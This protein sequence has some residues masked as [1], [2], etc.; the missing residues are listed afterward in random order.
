MELPKI[1]ALGIYDSD[2]SKPNVAISKN[3]K[4][5]MFEIEL[6]I[7]DGGVSYIDSS[8]ENIKKNMLI[9][10]KPGQV[11]HT[12]FPFKCFYV[13]MIVK[14]GILYDI[15]MKT[16]DF[17]EI[18]NRDKYQ[19]LFSEMTGNY[20]N[21]SEVRD[22]MVQSKLLELIYLINE[23]ISEL[24]RQKGSETNPDLI[25]KTVKYIDEHLTEDLSLEKLASINS[26]SSIHF[27]NVFKSATGKTLRTYVEEQRLKKAMQLLLTTDFTLTRIAYECGFSSQSYFSFAFKRKMN[28]SPREYVRNINNKYEI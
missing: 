28:C 5:S 6:P 14:S 16:P 27:H 26:I 1:V 7:E 25:E 10:G 24:S 4:V 21:F 8:S 2:I 22:I 23:N 13:H 17:S 3:R 15:L 18:Q 9:C 19:Q 20:N 12:K 11:R